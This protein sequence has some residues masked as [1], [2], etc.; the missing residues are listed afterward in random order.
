MGAFTGGLTYRRYYANEPLP[1]SFRDTFAQ[2]IAQ[3]AFKDIDLASDEERALGWCSP[4]FPLDT[5]IDVHEWLYDDYIVL[6]L[7][8]DTLSVPGPLLKIHA[9]AEERRV[10]AEQKTV[11]LSR[12]EKAE[13]KERVKLALRK[14]MLPTIKTIDLTWH[15]KP[16]A[17][18]GVV[19]FFSTIEKLNLEMMELFEATFGLMLTPVGIYTLQR[20]AAGGDEEKAE[21]LLELDVEPFADPDT[22]F[23]AMKEG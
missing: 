22:M 6:S 9:E 11:K 2:G 23:D 3:H 1:D 16:D 4:L 21:R 5:E 14:R 8:I 13:I 18:P 20:D 12:Y 17:G 15:W 19:R 7:R 10:M